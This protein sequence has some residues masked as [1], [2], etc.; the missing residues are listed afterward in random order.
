MTRRWTGVL[1][2]PPVV[3]IT[4]P[5]YASFTADVP[6]AARVMLPAAPAWAVPATSAAVRVS[7]MAPP[8]SSGP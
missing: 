3:S 6:A 4:M 8:R 1:P 7:C 2:V 5:L